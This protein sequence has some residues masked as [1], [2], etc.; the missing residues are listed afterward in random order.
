MKYQPK[1]LQS[2]CS[3]FH[4][5]IFFSPDIIQTG[6]GFLKTLSQSLVYSAAVPLSEHRVPY[7]FSLFWRIAVPEG[8][9][10]AKM[11]LCS[12]AR[13]KE[14]EAPGGI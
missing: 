8:D 5:C 13:G 10:A 12:I 9:L 3:E 2:H 14:L 1:F 4:F 7:S 11:R 6:A